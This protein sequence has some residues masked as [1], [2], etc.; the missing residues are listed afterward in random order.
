MCFQLMFHVQKGLGI[1]PATLAAS[2]PDGDGW[3]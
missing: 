1:A 2:G 3:H